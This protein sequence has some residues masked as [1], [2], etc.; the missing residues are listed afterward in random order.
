VRSSLRRSSKPEHLDAGFAW[1]SQIC[2]T[3]R[4]Q[5]SML[6]RINH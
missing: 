3:L 2:A 6:I 1:P 5:L 4:A